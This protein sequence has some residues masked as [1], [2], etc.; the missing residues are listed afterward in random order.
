MGETC[1]KQDKDEKYAHLLESLQE[2]DHLEN[3]GTDRKY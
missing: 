3:P 1:S 2:K